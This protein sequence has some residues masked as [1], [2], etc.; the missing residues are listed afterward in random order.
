MKLWPS[1]AILQNRRW[2]QW[3]RWSEANG[4]NLSNRRRTKERHIRSSFGRETSDDQECI[5]VYGIWW[6]SGYEKSLLYLIQLLLG[7][8]SPEGQILLLFSRLLLDCAQ[9]VE[10]R[11]NELNGTV[12]IFPL[13]SA[14]PNLSLLVYLLLYLLDPLFELP[15]LQIAALR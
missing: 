14:P 9:F 12:A 13:L 8:N 5:Y 6:I 7:S 3:G 1:I 15:L 10:G 2:N 4:N 11:R